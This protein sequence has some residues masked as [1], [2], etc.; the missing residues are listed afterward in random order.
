MPSRDDRD[1]LPGQHHWHGLGRVRFPFPVWQ[2]LVLSPSGPSPCSVWFSPHSSGE[3]QE[4]GQPGVQHVMPLLRGCWVWCQ[5]SS[6]SHLS[7][8]LPCSALPYPALLCTPWGLIPGAL[9]SRILHQ[10]RLGQGEGEEWEEQ[11]SW[12]S[13]PAVQGLPSPCP[14]APTTGLAPAPALGPLLSALRASSCRAVCSWRSP[15]FLLV[16]MASPAL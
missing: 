15:G 6:T 10:A 12:L 9:V 4:R 11:C 8:T 5:P 14:A 3:S 7:P 13:L 1:Q 2:R 16:L